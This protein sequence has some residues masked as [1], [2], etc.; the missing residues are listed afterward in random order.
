MGYSL[1]KEF[2]LKYFKAKYYLKSQDPSK[3]AFELACGQSIGNPK[4]RTK[5]DTNALFKKHFPKT[6]IEH[7]KNCSN[8][9]VW[10]PKANFARNLSINHLMS[11][12]M[13]G[14]MDIDNIEECR[15]IDLELPIK[16]S[17]PKYGIQGIRQ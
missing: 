4:K 13:G 1:H 15:L 5:Y 9:N 11:V 12:L 8:L 6:F 2:K 7:D 16:M 3:A 17:G 14:Q 10:F